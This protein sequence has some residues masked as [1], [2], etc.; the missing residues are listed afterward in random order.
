MLCGKTDPNRKEKP[1]E[2]ISLE[3]PNTVERDNI[4]IEL[5]LTIIRLEKL[6]VK[7]SNVKNQQLLDHMLTV[8][9]F[10]S[11][12]LNTTGERVLDAIEF[13]EVPHE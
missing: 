7:G 9:D 10:C 3:T 11:K 1:M 2:K 8:T 12:I 13:M 4:L 6:M 5:K